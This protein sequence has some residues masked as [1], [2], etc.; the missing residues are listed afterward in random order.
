MLAL[1]AKLDAVS[2][3]VHTNKLND[4]YIIFQHNYCRNCLD[5][6]SGWTLVDSETPP[7]DGTEKGTPLALAYG[8][9]RKWESI[10]RLWDQIKSRRAGGAERQIWQSDRSRH[11]VCLPPLAT[12]IRPSP[13]VR[14]S[15][16]LSAT[17]WQFDISETKGFRRAAR[18]GR[19]EQKKKLQRRRRAIRGDAKKEKGLMSTSETVGFFFFFAQR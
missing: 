9:N 4:P 13:S 19:D 16:R 12:V 14:L 2:S 8:Q 3:R 1:D 5:Q 17:P 6:I 7:A 11:A 18:D 10:E 15:V